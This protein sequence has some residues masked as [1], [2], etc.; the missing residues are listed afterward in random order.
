MV[1]LNQASYL[2]RNFCPIPSH[3][4]HL[5]NDPEVKRQK[6]ALPSTMMNPNRLQRG[7]R[8]QCHTALR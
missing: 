4:K 8:E 1:V 7:S 2:R 5:P 6:S 3:N